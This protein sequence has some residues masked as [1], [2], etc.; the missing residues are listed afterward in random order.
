MKR[1]KPKNTKTFAS[2]KRAIRD[3]SRER[4]GYGRSR[5]GS[6]RICHKISLYRRR[7]RRKRVNRDSKKKRTRWMSLQMKKFSETLSSS[8]LAKHKESDRVLL[9]LN[10]EEST[11]L[12]Y[13]R[14]TLK[15]AEMTLNHFKSQHQE[16]FIKTRIQNLVGT[17]KKNQSNRNWVS[18][19]KPFRKSSLMSSTAA[20]QRENPLVRA[21][22]ETSNRTLFNNCTIHS[23]YKM[24]EDFNLNKRANGW[25]RSNLG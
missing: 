3:L 10:R 2:Q 13:L 7:R 14:A 5:Q 24:E 17:L 25:K 20:E 1:E 9:R 15:A 18:W 16:T 12:R 23:F 22:V 6:Q 11:E 21:A 19:I 4:I 8:T